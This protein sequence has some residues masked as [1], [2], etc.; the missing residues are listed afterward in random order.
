MY[1]GGGKIIQFQK[2]QQFFKSAF[3]NRLLL[4]SKDIISTP[5]HYIRR[6]VDIELTGHALKELPPIS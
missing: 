4:I 6:G 3:F 5:I 1:K 2:I